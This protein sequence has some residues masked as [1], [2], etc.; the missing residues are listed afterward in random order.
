MN[1]RLF[2]TLLWVVLL[3]FFFAKI[4]IQI[5]GAHGWATSLPTW[6]IE[7]H[8]LLDVFWGGRPMTGYHA[9]VFP[10]IALVFHLPVF[11]L[12]RWTLRLE[13]RILACIMVF[14]VVEDF[15]WF[16]LNPAYGVAR[17]TPE[18]VWWHPYWLW[19]A[20]VDYWIYLPLAMVL[21]RISALPDARAVH[22]P[23]AA[24]ARF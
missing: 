6:R 10:F 23:L 19:G 21:L 9:W 16:V 1:T 18:T 22:V 5:E 20:P 2:P 7:A 8:W 12:A 24:R 13:C 17:F 11:F 3:A 14:W 15:L 4:E